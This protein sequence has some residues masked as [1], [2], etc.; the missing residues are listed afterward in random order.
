LNRDPGIGAAARYDAG[1]PD[2][3][4]A[5]LADAAQARPG[6]KF[7]VLGGG[8]SRLGARSFPFHHPHL[9]LVIALTVTAPEAQREH[10]VRFVLLDPDGRELAGAGGLLRTSPPHDARDSVLTFA[11]DLWNVGFE[12]PGDH[13]FRILV[14]GSERKR[15]PLIVEQLPAEP[16]PLAGSPLPGSPPE[17]PAVN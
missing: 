5:F 1:M 13:S 4:F 3:E 2:I 10:D 7:N 6:E 8:V 14:D 11:V 12:R 17:G 9:A 16:A 15:L